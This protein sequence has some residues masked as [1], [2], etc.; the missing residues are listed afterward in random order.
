MMARRRRLPVGM[1][2]ANWIDEEPP[3][4]P[5]LGK[6]IVRLFQRG[7][8]SWWLWMPLAILAALAANALQ[9]RHRV[10][11]AT[12]LLRVME[13]S[14]RTPGAELGAGTLRA[15]VQDLAFT[16]PHLVEVMGRHPEDYPDL[17]SDPASA[18]ADLRKDID[19]TIT[20]NEFVED[21]AAD[22]PPRSA[23]IALSYRSPQP[24][25]AL[26]VVRDLAELI[27]RSTLNLQ[28]EALE[29]QQAAAATALQRAEALNLSG[30]PDGPVPARGAGDDPRAEAARQRLRV[31]VATAT[32]ARLARRAGEQ[33]QTLHFDLVDA[34]RIPPR[35]TNLAR[36]ETL[37]MDLALAVIACWLVAGAFD[38][39]VLG[40]QDL[41]AAGVSVLGEVP[42]LPRRNAGRPRTRV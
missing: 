27:V 3:L 23:R 16:H 40:R 34:G 36:A 30:Q 12:V 10:Y 15:Q 7:A 9:N 39:R 2:A 21:R 18:V 32:N 4:R 6:L 20:D 25:L 26:A 13:G 17:T 28:K 35:P 5:M 31:T 38:P 19:L 11:E 24:D 29:R 37:V 42:P 8:G 1:D 22:D 14:V 33:Q 41:L